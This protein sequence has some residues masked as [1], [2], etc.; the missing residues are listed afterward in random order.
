MEQDLNIT[1][2]SPPPPVSG[3]TPCTD[4]ADFLTIPLIRTPPATY[5]ALRTIRVILS[6]AI[7]RQIITPRNGYV[8]VAALTGVMDV[9]FG[10]SMSLEEVLVILC[11]FGS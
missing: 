2:P 1:S 10:C 4:L 11:K 8:V 3:V 9:T 5:E 6:E 7:Y